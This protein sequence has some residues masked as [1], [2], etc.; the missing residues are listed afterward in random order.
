MEV[1]YE[2]PGTY[3]KPYHSRC[4][5]EKRHVLLPKGSHPGLAR[6]VESGIEALS[7]RAL[8]G[9]GLIVSTTGSAVEKPAAMARLLKRG[10][11]RFVAAFNADRSGD[12]MADRLR[13]R[14]RE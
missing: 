11:M 14:R 6:F 1:G 2:S 3:D 9:S 12:R 13:E 4:T 10:A 7:Y 5:G 8:R